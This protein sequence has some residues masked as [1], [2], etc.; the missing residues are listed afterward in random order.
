M[1]GWMDVETRPF[2]DSAPFYKLSV[3]TGHLYCV[4]CS[5]DSDLQFTFLANTRVTNFN[6]TSAVGT[7]GQLI[8]GSVLCKYIC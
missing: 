7:V 2:I 8:C 6:Q 3:A 5:S 4:N 1:D